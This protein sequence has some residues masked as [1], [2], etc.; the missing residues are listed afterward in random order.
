MRAFCYDLFLALADS[1]VVQRRFWRGRRIT[2][3]RFVVPLRDAKTRQT[4]YKCLA[5]AKGARRT[6]FGCKF[7]NDALAFAFYED[8]QHN[9][10]PLP[11]S[12]LCNLGGPGGPLQIIEVDM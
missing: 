12:T 1:F 3:T 4:F 7:V 6:W 2:Q 11:I 9:E 8:L 5:R 10:D